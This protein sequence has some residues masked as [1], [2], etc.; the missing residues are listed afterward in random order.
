MHINDPIGDLLTRIRN[1][2]MRHKKVVESP[3]SKARIAVLAV[4]QEEGYIRGYSVKNIRPGIDTVEV[5]LKY[6]DGHPVIRTIGRVS[7]PGRRSYTP[8]A[9]LKSIHN[10]LGINIL[11]TSKGVM[12]DVSARAL[13]IGGEVVCKVF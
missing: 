11:S 4:L 13:G 8:I 12:T 5:Q 3:S 10:G 1:A 9:K 2:H 7:T 6:A